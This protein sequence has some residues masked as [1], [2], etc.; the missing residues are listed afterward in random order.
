MVKNNIRKSLLRQGQLLSTEFVQKSNQIIQT[1]A[2]KELKINEVENILLYF[3]FKFEISVNLIINEINKHTKIYMPKILSRKEM[4]FNLMDS[5]SY[6]KKNKYGIDEINNKKYIDP[7]S[8]DIMLIPFVGVDKGGY[9]LG[10]GGG[11]FDRALKHIKNLEQRPKIIGLGYDYQMF[12]GDFA[13]DHDIK[14]DVVITE[15]NIISFS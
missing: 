4:K 8:L 13:E 1:T 12:N 2:I 10:Y 7:L 3:P 15:K 11:Y 14:Y 5:K 9:R 6:L